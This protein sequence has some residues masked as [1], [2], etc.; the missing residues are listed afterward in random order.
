MPNRPSGTALFR[1]TDIEGSTR[2]ARQHPA[3]WSGTTTIHHAIFQGAVESRS[4]AVS[5]G[6]AASLFA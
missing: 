2:L 4:R 3:A 5:C 6:Q 1:F